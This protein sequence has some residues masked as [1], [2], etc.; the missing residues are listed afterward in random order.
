MWPRLEINLSK[1]QENTKVIT[2]I[3]QQYGGQVDGVV[4]VVAGEPAVARAMLAGGLQGLADSR[5]A[6]IVRMRL[7]GINC[8]ITLLRSPALSEIAQVIEYTDLSLNSE[9][10]VLAALAKE[11]SR[12]GKTHKVIVMTDLGD[13]REGVAPAHLADLV[14]YT[15]S[16]NN[17][18]LV[19]IGTNFT[20]FSGQPPTLEQLR[21]LVELKEQLAQGIDLLISAGTSSTLH[22]INSGQWQ[23]AWLKQINHW[24]IGESIFFGHDIIT[25]Q[26]LANCWQNACLL[27]AEIIEIQEKDPFGDQR[28]KR[29]IVALGT[30]EL[31]AGSLRPISAGVQVLGASSDHLVVSLTKDYK[32]GDILSFSLD[33]QALL[34]SAT[35]PYVQVICIK[36]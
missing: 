20:C 11:A 15:R 14:A 10:T 17:I 27:K 32:I 31:G 1:I 34:V 8:P 26:P 7:A 5:L 22:L 13:G 21:K 16:L 6:N 30:Q 3:I 2:E 24:R 28:A 29:G 25:Q 12:Q 19:G 4:K 9:K 33:Y 18:E 35:S 36:D 23:A